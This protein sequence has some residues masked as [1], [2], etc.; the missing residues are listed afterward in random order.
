MVMV[1]A[2]KKKAANAT[3]CFVASR[4]VAVKNKRVDYLDSMM[5]GRR[6]NAIKFAITQG[7]RQRQQKRSKQSLLRAEMMK[8]SR[9]EEAKGHKRKEAA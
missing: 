9:K 2:F 3:I 4:M 8:N 7:H 5:T 1:S 6:E